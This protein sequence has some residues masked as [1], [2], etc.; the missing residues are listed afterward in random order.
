[1]S[2]DAK[3]REYLRR[4]VADLQRANRRLDQMEADRHEPIA[5]VAMGCRL[6]GGVSSPEELWQLVLDEVDCVSGLPDDRGWSDDLYDPDVDKPGKSYAREGAF[7][8]DVAGFDPALFGISPREALAMDPQ[9]RLLLETSWE[10]FERA[11]IAPTSVRGSQIGVYVGVMYHDYAANLDRLPEGS[12]GYFG[13]G[14]SGSVAS[15]R[16]SYTLGLNGPAVTLDTACSSSLVAIHL[17]AGALRRGECSMALAGGVTVMASPQMYV[18]FSRQGALSPDGRCRAFAGTAA[19]TSLSE[20]VGLL[21]LERLS[22]ARRNGHEILAVIRGSAV[23]QD[24]ASNGLTAPNGV[25]QQRV[26]QQALADARL[27]AGE[28]DVIEAH[29]TG[30]K[31]GDPIEAQALIAT[32]G[33]EHPGERPLRLGSLKSNIGHTQAAAGVA[34]VMKMV[35]AM[36]HGVVPKTLHVDEPTPKVDWTAGSVRLATEHGDWP[37]T[38]RPRRAGVSAFGVSGTNAHVILEEPPAAEPVEPGE[39]GEPAGPVVWAVSGQ[40][41]EAR[42]VQGER[43]AAYAAEHPEAGAADIARSLAGGR[44]MLEHRAVVIAADRE[45]AVTGLRS[46]ADDV[47]ASGVIA[48][49]P[50]KGRLALLFTGQGSQ[51]IGMGQELAARFPVFAEAM[52]TVCAELD[53][54]LDRPL[55]EVI[56][57]DREALDRTGFTQPALF[58]LEVALFR[59]VESWGVRPDF[60]AGHSIGELAA[61]HVAGAIPLADAALLVAAR[62]RLMQQLPAGGAMVAV[63]ATEEEVAPLLTPRTSIAAINGQRSL[64]LSGDEE[65]VGEIV[66]KLAA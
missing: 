27:S 47:P 17:A 1:M 20:G 24:G 55:R 10:V 26:I 25:A 51:R 60:V 34:G 29:G 57:G 44:A 2:D 62:G 63:Q 14:N 50:A 22:D 64:V 66:D 54:H 43:L 32:Y 23:N 48:G 11:G 41:E 59:L 56:A 13:I 53:P 6:P 12:E 8:R 15:G 58:A 7:L 42:R 3:L 36:R 39:P 16:V 31:L 21:L 33:Q 45:A 30:T 19:G 52:D 49:A 28:V 61:A 18:A 5:I 35:E 9:Q 4:T 38:G 40:T 37:V 65:P 46:L